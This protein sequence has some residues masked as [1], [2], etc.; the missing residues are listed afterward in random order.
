MSEVSATPVRVL[1]PILWRVILVISCAAALSACDSG[2]DERGPVQL[3]VF[4]ITY[5]VGFSP[6]QVVGQASPDTVTATGDIFSVEDDVTTLNGNVTVMGEVP[7]SVTI[8]EGYPGENGPV[9]I[10][11]T[12]DGGELWTVP[13][14]VLADDEFSRLVVSGYYVSVQTSGGE[15]RGQVILPGYVPATV[16][17]DA[18]EVIPAATSAGSGTAGFMLNPDNGLI[19]LRITTDGISDAIGAG[20]RGAVTGARGEEFIDMEQSLSDPR[21]WGTVD[22]NDPDAEEYVTQEGAGFIIT[23]AS[24]FSLE[25]TANPGGELRGQLVPTGIDVVTAP[26]DND[27]VVREGTPVATGATG[28]ATVTWNGDFDQISVAVNS[29]IEDAISVGLYQGDA[30]EIGPLVLELTQDALYPGYWV[31]QRESLTPQQGDAFRADGLYVSVVTADYP[32]GEL[33][34]QL[35]LN[36]PE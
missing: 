25:T 8:N 5:Q 33:R 29:D 32:E 9:Y 35:S 16:P 23:G 10:T 28:T 34:G 20:L 22:I 6:I 30:G 36:P 1:R 31:V 12:N 11:L 14:T 4:T 19:R 26:L 7:T 21:V 24:Y 2:A 27:Q 13:E 3:P 15:L 18:D 17:L